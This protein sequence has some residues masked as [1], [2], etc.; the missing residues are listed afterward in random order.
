MAL[1]LLVVRIGQLIRV[2]HQD[3][4]VTLIASTIQIFTRVMQDSV[5]A[6]ILM[7]QETVFVILLNLMIKPF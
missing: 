7:M 6:V 4:I 2:S 1:L 3:V 5:I